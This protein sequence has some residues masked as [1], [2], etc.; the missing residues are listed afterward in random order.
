MFIHGM[1]S[2]PVDWLIILTTA[3]ANSQQLLT[4]THSARNLGFIF[5]EHLIF[6]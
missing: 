6:F 2:V 5:D 1:M 4:T 3:R